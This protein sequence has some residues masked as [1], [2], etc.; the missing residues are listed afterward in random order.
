MSGKKM[1]TLGQYMTVIVAS[2][3]YGVMVGVVLM[4]RAA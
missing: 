3:V 4:I 1:I 2:F